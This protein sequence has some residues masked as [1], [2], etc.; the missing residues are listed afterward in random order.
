[1]ER[2]PAQ[3]GSGGGSRYTDIDDDIPF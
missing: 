2:R 1:M 3:A